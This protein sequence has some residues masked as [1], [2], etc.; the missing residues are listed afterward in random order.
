MAECDPK[1]LKRLER[2]RKKAE[3]QR[4]KEFDRA[5]KKV[6]YPKTYC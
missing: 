4:E 6:H 1:E 2:E 3:K 5:V